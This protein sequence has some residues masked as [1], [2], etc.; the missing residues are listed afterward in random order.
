MTHKHLP[1]AERVVGVFKEMLSQ[2]GRDH[3]GDKHFDELALMIESAV[4]TAVLEEIEHAADKM[5]AVVE[6][7]RKSA[8]HL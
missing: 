5:H 2:S 3:V 7:I 4:S 8:E 1:H 6:S